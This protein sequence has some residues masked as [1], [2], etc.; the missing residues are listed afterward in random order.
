MQEAY[1]YTR[2]KLPSGSGIDSYNA[3]LSAPQAVP[4]E[5][6]TNGTTTIL[7][8]TT[9][10]SKPPP[11]NKRTATSSMA[12]RPLIPSSQSPQSHSNN[13]VVRNSIMA[14]SVAGM[15]STVVMYPFDV[16][17]TKMQA[18]G[19]SGSTAVYRGPV[20]VL[21]H[22]L[23]HGGVRALYTGIVPVLGAQGI[24]KSTVFAVNNVTQAFLLDFHRLEHHKQGLLHYEPQLSLLDRFWSGA[25]GGAVN[26]LLFVTPVEFVR[27]QM[28][29]QHTKISSGQLARDSKQA[30]SLDIVRQ[31]VSKHGWTSLWRG[32]SWSVARDGWG[33]GWF[34]VTMAW[35]Q[36]LLTAPGEKPSSSATVVAGAMSGLA[37]W[38][39][40]LPL[41]T[42]KTWVQSADLGVTSSVTESV[43]IILRQEGPRG[44]VEKLFR[45][46]QMAYGRGVPSAAITISVY[47]YIYMYLE[48]G[49]KGL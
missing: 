3:L 2:R 27:N 39:A 38:V 35:T 4:L 31:S 7:M 30:T 13:N 28:I 26:A 49:V 9:P 24:Y 29:A 16:L 48:P 1:Q 43:S 23:Y 18:S 14:G 12:K 15:A 46:W 5:Y 47:S 40:S 17:R 36:Q 20:Q 19:V 6:W 42:I 41:D 37:F 11:E 21:Q 45:G 10:T 25:I 33:C 22:T 8:P 44:V 32:A 34:F